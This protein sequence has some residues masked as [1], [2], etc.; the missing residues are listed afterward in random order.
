MKK[1]LL[2]SDF[3]KNSEASAIYAAHL[4]KA[5]NA[6]ID[7]AHVS[8]LISQTGIYEAAHKIAE[9]TMRK[10]LHRLA[11]GMEK[12]IQ[13]DLVFDTLLLTGS[14]TDAL[15]SILSHYDLVIMS[16]KGTLDLDRFFLGSTTK[17]LIQQNKVPILVVPPQYKY[18]SIQTIVWALDD[19][20]LQTNK[21]IHPLVSIAHHF[22]AKLEIFHQ[23]EGQKDEGL[24]L[25]LAI[26]LEELNYSVHY[27]FDQSTITDAILH[28]A[29]ETAAQLICMIHHQRHPLFQV[30]NPSKTLQS[31]AKSKI[32][33]LVLPQLD[34][35]GA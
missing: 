19:H 31:I 3:S 30:F 24:L 6:Q 34:Q 11:L 2:P 22:S 7:I 29:E 1:I 20:V 28:F 33:I 17:Y 18:T 25:D 13:G 26:F 16:A 9:N 15:S 32:P 10:K 8:H 12:T 14:T 21:Q 35:K 5:L 27:N 23:D 4:A